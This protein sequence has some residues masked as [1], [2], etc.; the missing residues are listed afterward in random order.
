VEKPWSRISQAWAPLR[1]FLLAIQGHLYSLALRFLFLQTHTTSY[2]FYSKLLYT[3]NEK[4][5]KPE[6]KPYPLPY[7]LRNPFRNLNSD[8]SQ[9]FALKP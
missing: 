7:G 4:G 1:V 8:I 5:G 6:R 2:S 3:V 9:D